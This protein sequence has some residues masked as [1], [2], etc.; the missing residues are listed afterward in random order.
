MATLALKNKVSIKAEPSEVYFYLSHLKYHYLWNPSMRHLSSEGELTLGMS[1][2][3]KSKLLGGITV[4][5]RNKV[6]ELVPNKKLRLQNRLGNIKYDA[7]FTLAKRRSRTIVTCNIIIDTKAQILGMTLPVLK[8]LGNRELQ[9][10]LY[11]LK[12][13]VENKMAQQLDK[14]NTPTVSV[15]I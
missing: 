5:S 6:T 15:T 4:S 8:Q 1:Y 7:E 11:Y 12:L 14:T 13:A 2:E 9:S 10:D 3:A